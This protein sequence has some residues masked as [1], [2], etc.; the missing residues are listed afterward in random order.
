VADGRITPHHAELTGFD[1]EGVVLSDG[2]RLA[3]DRA[4]LALGS[5]SP[6]FPFLS[7]AHRAL[8]EAEPDGTQLYRHLVHPRIA[9]LGFAGFNHGFMH[10]PAAEVGAQWLCCLWRGELALPPVEEMERS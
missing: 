10:L 7:E 2:S 6:R 8:L 3:C 1:A 9:N 4:V 5:E